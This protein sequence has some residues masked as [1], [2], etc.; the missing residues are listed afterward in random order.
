MMFLELLQKA[1]EGDCSCCRLPY[2]RWSCGGTV[3]G[4]NKATLRPLL[5]WSSGCGGL[6]TVEH[7]IMM[8]SINYTEN[9]KCWFSSENTS[10]T[11]K[12]HPKS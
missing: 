10:L 7:G 5:A 11:G 6:L 9:R 2:T 4:I 12:Y 1:Q 8:K 3:D